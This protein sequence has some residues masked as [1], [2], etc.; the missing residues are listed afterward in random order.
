MGRP[1]Y[2]AHFEG[3]VVLQNAHN[4]SA[5]CA[6]IWPPGARN[7]TDDAGDVEKFG[8]PHA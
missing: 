5:V 8:I 3:H 4:V 1:R 6:Y 7:A 2:G